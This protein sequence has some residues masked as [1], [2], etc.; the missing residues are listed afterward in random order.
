[1]ARSK[2]DRTQR[3]EHVLLTIILSNLTKFSSDLNLVLTR[4]RRYDF[5]NIF[6]KKF[7]EN[8][9]VFDSKQS[10]IIQNVDHNIG[11]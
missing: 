4:D 6:A 1:V 2:G 10:K 11:F 7:G 9:G 8:I 3:A 5:K